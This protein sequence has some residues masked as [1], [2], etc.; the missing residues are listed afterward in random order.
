MFW[1]QLYAFRYRAEHRFRDHLPV[2]KLARRNKFLDE[3]SFGNIGEP[4]HVFS[5]DDLLQDP[6]NVF[7]I[8]SDKR[9]ERGFL[10]GSTMLY[11]ARFRINL[12][13]HLL[14]N[15]I[16]SGRH[17]ELLKQR[18]QYPDHLSSYARQ[19]CHDLLQRI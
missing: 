12:F 17:S 11:N 4:D 2:A 5:V 9:F 13:E 1:Y 16:R 19:R 18:Q 15:H 7:H 6:D 8:V 3:C 14:G 10:F